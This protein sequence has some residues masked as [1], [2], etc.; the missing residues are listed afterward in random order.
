MKDFNDHQ[1]NA[2][3]HI[4]ASAAT[5]VLGTLILGS[6]LAQRGFNLTLFGVGVIIYAILVLL[7]LKINEG[8]SAQK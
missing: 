4:F 3:Q 7:V 8:R 6:F 5:V 2:L 1:L